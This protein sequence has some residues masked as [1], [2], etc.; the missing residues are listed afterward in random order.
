M[1]TTAIVIGLACPFIGIVS[2][3]LDAIIAPVTS[4]ESI[5]TSSGP[6]LLTVKKIW[7]EE[8]LR[9]QGKQ[10]SVFN[11]APSSFAATARSASVV[12]SD[13]KDSLDDFKKVATRD[14]SLMEAETSWEDRAP[15]QCKMSTAMPFSS[16]MSSKNEVIIK[17]VDGEAFNSVLAIVDVSFCIVTEDLD[18]SKETFKAAMNDKNDA[19]VTLFDDN[20]IKNFPAIAHNA[21]YKVFTHRNKIHDIIAALAIHQ[22]MM[23]GKSNGAF[24]ELGPEENPHSIALPFG[25]LALKHQ[26]PD[27]N[28]WHPFYKGESTGGYRVSSKDCKSPAN[29]IH[30]EYDFIIKLPTI[31]RAIDGVTSAKE[32]SSVLSSRGTCII[33][34]LAVNKVH[35]TTAH[36]YIFYD[37]SYDLLKNSSDMISWTE[38]EDG[39]RDDV[40]ACSGVCG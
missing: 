27:S 23:T 39:L 9:K 25:T 29:P 12:R 38:H 16:E 4:E 21:I 11:V 6:Q 34:N 36:W 18:T 13:S 31:G 30:P 22:I 3:H 35:G 14:R 37:A 32:N 5:K 20:S 17:L 7:G 40:F 28:A 19:T 1:K 15:R 33:S 8:F 10:G 26:R 24:F 2:A